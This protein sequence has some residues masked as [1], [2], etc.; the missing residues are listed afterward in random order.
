MSPHR[1]SR[2]WRISGQA[3]PLRAGASANRNRDRA[4]GARPCDSRAAA[5]D[6]D[7]GNSLGSWFYAA[8][9][10]AGAAARELDG[11]NSLGSGSYA[12]SRI[13]A[14]PVK[15]GA[16]FRIQLGLVDIGETSRPRPDS[17]DSPGSRETEFA[18]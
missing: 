15:A 17:P 9:R 4:R 5:R 13:A 2:I 16:L 11:G 12:A 7:G 3:R 18:L 8:T 1:R 10:V 14:V 6:L